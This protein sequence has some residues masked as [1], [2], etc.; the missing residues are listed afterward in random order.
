MPRIVAFGTIFFLCQRYDGSHVV[1]HSNCRVITIDRAILTAW[2]D[3]MRVPSGLISAISALVQQMTVVESMLYMSKAVLELVDSLPL[4]SHTN[5]SPCFPAEYF[6]L[7]S[8]ESMTISTHRPFMRPL[9]GSLSLLLY[10]CDLA[11][12]FLL[13]SP[14]FISAVSRPFLGIRK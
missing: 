10:K 1:A 9:M 12:P 4:P 2:Q 13:Q 3:R 5:N 8:S 14:E 11:L 7:R 6:F